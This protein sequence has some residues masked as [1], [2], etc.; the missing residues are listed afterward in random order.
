MGETLEGLYRGS[1]P[2]RGDPNQVEGG[3]GFKLGIDEINGLNGEKSL[4]LKWK[5]THDEP[6]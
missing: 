2:C 3:V 4:S 6:E 5:Q 1:C